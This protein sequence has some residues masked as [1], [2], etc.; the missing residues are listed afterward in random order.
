MPYARPAL[1]DLIA[2]ATQDV[3]DATI[4]DPA[5]ANQ[6]TGLLN[7]AVMRVMAKVFAG[8]VWGEYGYIDWVSKMAVP[9]TAEDEYLVGWAALK[10]V[11]PKDAVAASGT[12]VIASGCTNG[13][14]L[15]SGTSIT[16]S[17]GL[18]YTTTADATA[19]SGALSASITCAAKGTIGN[20]DAG[21]TLTI[22]GTVDGIPAG[23]TAGTALT[24]GADQETNDDLRTRMLQ[25]YAAPPQGGDR[26]DYVEWALAVS[27]VTRAWAAANGAGAGT[28]VVYTMWD[29][30]EAAHGG[31]PQGDDGVSQYDEGP[32][33]AP[34]DTVA[35]GDQLTVADAI[36]TKQPATALVYSVAPINLPVAFTIGGVS[37]GLQAAVEAA[38]DAM[39]V[40]LG[41]VGGTTDPTTGEA[42][43]D[44]DPSDWYEAISSVSGI[45]RYTVASPTA[46]ITTTAGQLPTRGA[47]TFT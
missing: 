4:T 17:D 45:G 13:S 30:A 33:G 42:W 20:A 47:V 21:I 26:A 46:P 18:A 10:G 29:N 5:T 6:L 32:G 15:P 2:Q 39:F 37:A 34:R 40:R 3:L 24:G 9:W 22:A 38:L 31:F 41:N 44:I 8:L 23:G 16:R 1:T 43:P 19:A 36:V 14:V 27:G 12:F 25:V 7:Q 11:Y 28:V 35:T